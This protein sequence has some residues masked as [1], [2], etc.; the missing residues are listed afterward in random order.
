MVA[1]IDSQL[2]RLSRPLSE[3]R[4]RLCS[5]VLHAVTTARVREPIAASVFLAIGT[6]LSIDRVIEGIAPIESVVGMYHST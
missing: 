2:N 6:D 4:E 5:E 1:F 3:T